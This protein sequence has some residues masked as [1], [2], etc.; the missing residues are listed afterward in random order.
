LTVVVVM[1]LA[2]AWAAVL[3]PP[4]LRARARSRPG[5]SITEF[6]RRLNVLRRTGGFAMTPL[7][8]AAPT[9][10]V[11]P[12]LAR[13]RR[14]VSSARRRRHDIFVTLLAGA[15]ATGALGFVP[16]LH[17]LWIFHLVFDACLA[18]YTALLIRLR[19]AKAERDMKVRYLP[20]T[21]PVPELA[22]R[23]SASS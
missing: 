8:T 18:V 1:I 9:T 13:P 7:P 14:P 6:H 22:Y 17:V 5:D 12:A 20:A 10:I 19:N 11:A 3:V 16:I 23:R 4:V 21:A 15:V 2:V